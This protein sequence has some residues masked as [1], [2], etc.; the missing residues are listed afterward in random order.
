MT[1]VTEEG[2]TRNLEREA[3]A[4]LAG[5]TSEMIRSGMTKGQLDQIYKRVSQSTY[6][7]GPESAKNKTPTKKKRKTTTRRSPTRMSPRKK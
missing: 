3:E 1:F 6:T 4:C 2:A 5:L 7:D